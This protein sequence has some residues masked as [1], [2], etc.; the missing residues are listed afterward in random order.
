MTSQQA[1]KKIMRAT[2]ILGWGWMLN[3]LLGTIAVIFL[4]YYIWWNLHLGFLGIFIFLFGFWVI[5]SVFLPELF[6]V[7][8][9]FPAQMAKR[10]VV[11]L[12]ILKVISENTV[13]SLSKQKVELWPELIASSMSKEDFLEKCLGN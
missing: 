3:N 10:G 8:N 4:V 12:A 13:H 5:N 9:Y 1:F 2:Y 7:Y 11:R 6:R